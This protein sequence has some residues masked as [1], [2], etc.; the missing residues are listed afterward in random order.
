MNPRL[1]RNNSLPLLRELSPLRL[2][3]SPKQWKPQCQV[4]APL[5]RPYYY[6]YYGPAAPILQ[7]LWYNACSIRCITGWVGSQAR[8]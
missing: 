2:S 3:P 6:M 5:E 1:P 8:A 7:V 4:F